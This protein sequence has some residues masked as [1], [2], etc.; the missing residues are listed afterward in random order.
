MCSNIIY[1][2]ELEDQMIPF[3]PS[4]HPR[5][6]KKYP[7]KKQRVTNKE[8]FILK[9]KW[10]HGIDRYE[11]DYL[12]YDNISKDV[13][14]TC[15]I[16]GDFIQSRGNHLQGHGCSECSHL[17]KIKN[18]R[19]TTSWFINK[20][21]EVH[22]DLYD[23]SKVSYTSSNGKITLSC[24]HGHTFTIRAADHI[25]G[26][27][28]RFCYGYFVSNKELQHKIDKI[29]G[30]GTYTLPEQY[31][32]EAN[33]TRGKFICNIHGDFETNINR[34]LS[35]NGCPKC[36]N[37][38]SYTSNR[39]LVDQHND[40]CIIYHVRISNEEVQFDKIGI[41]KTNIE[42]RFRGVKKKG[43]D[44]QVVNSAQLPLIDAVK[45]EESIKQELGTLK[46]SH[47][48]HVLK[49]INES[50]WTECFEPKAYDPSKYFKRLEQC[51]NTI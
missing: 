12:V 25:R 29:H 13:T 48:I 4:I 34:L 36:R 24:E 30:I 6:S 11:Y 16:H 10:I 1:P 37:S 35:G 50:G 3:D 9:S 39:I 38:G 18:R 15:P 22:G 40:P 28:C 8:S 27:G 5:S 47:K 20:A 42:Y 33:Y 7:L 2:E 43:F 32:Y 17:E 14:I 31:E 26:R 21:K 44:V 46:L 19:K 51:L 23:Y 49:N 41:T 45:L